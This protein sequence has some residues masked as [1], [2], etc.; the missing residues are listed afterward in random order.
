MHTL[1][2]LLGLAG[3]LRAQQPLSTRTAS[4]RIEARLDEPS[5]EVRGHETLTWRNGGLEPTDKLVFHL[6]MNA[7]K[8][9][10]STFLRERV[11]HDSPA[12][13]DGKW[14]FVEVSEVAVR[15]DGSEVPSTLTVPTKGDQTLATLTL[16]RAVAPGESVEVLLDFTT[17]LP[18]IVDRTGVHD[19]F[20]AVAQWFPKVA[21]YACEPECRFVADEHHADSEFYA[22]FGTYDVTLDLPS[23][24]GVGATGI[25]TSAR[26]EGMRQVVTYHADDV[27]DFV[28][29][30]DARFVEHATDV[31]DGSGLP[32]I[33]V[34][35]LGRSSLDEQVARHLAAAKTTLVE[36]GRRLGPYPYTQ[37]T[38]V[39][40]PAGSEQA[41]GMEYPTLYFTS[42]EPTPP[43]VYIAELTTAHEGAHQWFQGMIAS[44][45]VNEAWLDEGL[46]ELATGW[47]L[48]ALTPPRGLIYELLGHRVT[49]R[50]FER[51]A[52][53]GDAPDAVAIPSYAFSS[54]SAYAQLTYRKTS[55][56]MQTLA[57]RLG[58]PEM[59]R[60][61]RAYAD[62]QRFHHPHRADF[63]AAFDGI[64]P[65]LRRFLID[66]IEQPGR[67]DYA[68]TRVTTE[69]RRAD[70]GLFDTPDGGVREVA[71]ATLDGE[72]HS[73]ILVER[74]GDY[75]LPVTVR[76][77]FAD[78]SERDTL[79]ELGETRWRRI[80]LDSKSPLVEARLYPDQDTP[81]DLD[82]YDDG[83]RVTPDAGP[84]RTLVTS[85]ELVLAMMLSWVL[86]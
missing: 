1:V 10:Q 31:D 84:R 38:V 52:L 16:E 33:H 72:R 68:I 37:L 15:R 53:R 4:Y 86:R 79:V 18:D 27:H 80:E 62:A 57:A 70:E 59:E 17:R 56:V 24:L 75:A 11:A 83:K 2:V 32:P 12:I 42:D 6:Y 47:V 41:S 30:A 21:V 78:G 76:A 3:A 23:Q 85:A 28:F 55:L 49:Y 73:T 9:E 48:D 81:I 63:F 82:R 64:P 39:E 36:L 43:G 61:L 54:K 45:E 74:L 71:H 66:T 46:T 20:Y 44:D 19:G 34:V 22:D 69:P 77:T 50:D 51:L 5:R 8:N 29:T 40:V 13:P 67:F 60:R 65:V 35:L 58:G 14:G 25:R 7:F 26:A